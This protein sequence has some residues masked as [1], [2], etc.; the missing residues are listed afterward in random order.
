MQGGGHYSRKGAARALRERRGARG[1]SFL[2]MTLILA[3]G[4]G[5]A[6][7]LRLT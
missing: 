1:G 4:S 2:R 7:A 3:P 5:A 6:A